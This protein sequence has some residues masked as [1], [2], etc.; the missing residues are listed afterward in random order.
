MEPFVEKRVAVVTQD[1][2]LIVVGQPSSRR[3]NIQ[4][5]HDDYFDAPLSNCVILLPKQM[6]P[7][8]INLV[9]VSAT[10]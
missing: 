3:L 10:R 7:F 6:I 8:V 2:R 1:G 5:D 4:D 9:N